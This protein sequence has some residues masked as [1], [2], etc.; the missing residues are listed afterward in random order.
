MSDIL[1]SQLPRTTVA[2]G[3]DLLIIDSN[4]SSGGIVTHSIAVKHLIQDILFEDG[5]AIE[6]SIT[7]KNDTNTGFYRPG[8]DTIGFTTSGLNRMVIG[9][10]GHVG[11]GTQSPTEK[12]TVA[13]GKISLQNGGDNE[14]VLESRDGGSAVTQKSSLPLIFATDDVK[15][16]A[17]NETGVVLV[18][19]D[20]ELTDVQMHI[21]GGSLV[22]NGADITGT[23]TGE[24]IIG[25]RTTGH[26]PLLTVNFEGALANTLD[27]YGTPGQVL[28]SQGTNSP[29][30]WTT[31]SGGGGGGT[32]DE[33]F[34]NP[35][36]LPPD[37]QIYGQFWFNSDTEILYIWEGTD[38]KEVGGSGGGGSTI[39]IGDVNPPSADEGNLFWNTLTKKLYAWDDDA[40]EWVIVG[41]Q[42]P[43]E[44]DLNGG[45]T[46]PT[47]APVVASL[48][49]S[50]NINTQGDLNQWLVDS[51]GYLEEEKVE[52]SPSD[53]KIY[54][55][56]T[57][58][59]TSEWV[60]IS[61]EGTPGINGQDATVDV[62]DVRTGAPGTSVIITN[63]GP[64]ASN[65]V[66][67]F[68]IPRGDKGEDG[69]DGEDGTGVRIRGSFDYV[70]P[71]TSDP[72]ATDPEEGDLWI[73]TNGDG[74]AWDGSSWTNVGP[75]Q[76]PQGEAATVTVG[77]T[78]T[79]D[80][81]TDAIV[82]NSGDT[83]N[84]VLEFTIPKGEKGDKGDDGPGS[85]VDVDPNTITGTAGSLASVTNTGTVT[86]AVFQFTIPRGDEGIQGPAGDPQKVHVG[87]NPP[88]DS[89]EGDLWYETDTDILKI[90]IGDDWFPITSGEI[91]TLQEVLTAG[92]VSDKSI[93]LTDG[94][95]LI[96]IDPQGNWIV[97][98]GSDASATPKIELANFD[99]DAA[100]DNNFYM[101]LVDGSTSVDFASSALVTTY[102]F[103]FNE[104][105]PVIQFTSDGKITASTF[106]MES[107]PTLPDPTP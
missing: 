43:D 87:E 62:G 107:L 71:P 86:D 7:F 37:P 46:F 64:S 53:A 63:S 90:Q 66:F 23:S 32:A 47:L 104:D 74:W 3:E 98:G 84:A 60:E 81:D 48:P 76:G 18:N 61:A 94:N 80:P 70:G 25:Y 40:G 55:R 54:G 1:I 89:E 8:D 78:T 44:I 41:P 73:D 57:D 19:T 52:E 93:E 49:N 105:D 96:H 68:T 69:N 30:T 42:D 4:Q 91:N 45:I 38:W 97:V 20:D 65:A 103:H 17:I 56:K 27:N 26:R 100:H 39:D 82:I 11:I 35:G 106:D 2:D 102:D 29:F 36:P 85:T 5:T 75:I 58:G 10:T 13:N 6:P 77:T 50:D 21:E 14:L 12:L 79:G 59:G 34:T 95:D 88:A 51:V 15:R 24:V 101:Q 92:N 28:T 99:G 31:V 16:V 72:E 33:P 9:P 22:V 67:D 83:S